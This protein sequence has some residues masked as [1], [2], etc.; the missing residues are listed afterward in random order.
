MKQRGKPSSREQAAGRGPAIV[1]CPMH[2]IAYDADK[3]VCPECAKP[4]PKA[5]SVAVKGAG[6]PGGDDRAGRRA[7]GV[8]VATCWPLGY[9]VPA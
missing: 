8:T 6:C 1:R 9:P 5:P 7:P 4:K 2:G 3:E